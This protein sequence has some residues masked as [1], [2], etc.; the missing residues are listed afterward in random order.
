MVLENLPL[1]GDPRAGRFPEESAFFAVHGAS[2]LSLL[3]LFCRK[4]LRQFYQFV[5][6][7]AYGRR[8]ALRRIRKRNSETPGGCQP[9][10]TSD[11]GCQGIRTWSGTVSGLPGNESGVASSNAGLHKFRFYPV[12]VWLKTNLASSCNPLIRGLA[13]RPTVPH[14]HEGEKCQGQGDN[15]GDFGNDRRSDCDLASGVANRLAWPKS[16]DTAELPCQ[17]A[18]VGSNHDWAASN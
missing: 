18:S 7:T 9:G 14:G 13:S 15:V 16:R 10:S 6:L 17:I 3:V 11:R 1:R 4:S 12:W 8:G 5:F 2:N